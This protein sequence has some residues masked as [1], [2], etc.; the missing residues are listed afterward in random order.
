MSEGEGRLDGL[1]AL[2]ERVAHR[3]GGHP[4]VIRLRA[5]LDTYDRAGGGLVAGG[6]AY[7]SLLALLPGL[8]LG[9]SAIGIVMQNPADQKRVVAL[10]AQAMPP[11]EELSRLALN[12]VSA[13]AVPTGIFA[14]ATLLWGSSRFY[15]NLDTAFSRI[16]REAP[17]RNAIVQTVR[18]IALIAV[19]VVVPVTLL[20]LGSV[21]SWLTQFAPDGLN[22]SAL[23]ATTLQIASPVV[24]LLAFG[25]AVALC[26]RLVPNEL[27]PWRVLLPPAAAVGLV[28]AVLTQV[29]AL[30]APRLV[31]VAA[32]YGTVF[33]I[34]GLL[35]WL[36]IAF[37][38]L[39]IGAAWTDVRLRMGPLVEV[40]VR[41]RRWTSAADRRAADAEGVTPADDGAGSE[42]SRDD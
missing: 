40:A 36:S 32:L 37:N 6:L 21:V 35:A 9:L 8:L 31:G 16:F 28:L 34:L 30:I 24:S 41:R 5:I 3:V 4:G 1:R 19:L 22:L 15:A 39:L 38:V 10:I 23:I 20:A 29:Y 18:G 26:Y 25:L 14:I 11:F 7:T 42:T 17:R 33:A 13:S 2:A 27:V 12:Q